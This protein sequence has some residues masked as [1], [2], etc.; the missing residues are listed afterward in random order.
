MQNSSIPFLETA[1][2]LAEA[3]APLLR[4]YFRTPI[5][6][7]EKSDLTPVTLADRA[8]EQ[9]MRHIIRQTHPDHGI[10]GEEMGIQ[11]IE[12]DYLWVLDPIDGTKSFIT[13]KPLFG[14]L[15]ALLYQGQPILGLLEQPILRERWLGG[16]GIFTTLNQQRIQVRSCT[17]LSAAT[18]Y[19]T[20]PHMFNPDE[21]QKFETVRKQI[22]LP[23]YGC[24]CYAYGLLAMG[25]VDLV[26]EAGLAPYDYCA[27]VPIVEQ[28]GGIMT[29]WQGRPLGLHSQGQVIA[30]GDRHLHQQ[31]LELLA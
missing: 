15:I 10:L 27:L 13:G 5:V 21:F 17:H 14:T 20:S 18:L 22:K 6:V 8:V 7:E 29:D 4:H 25:L 19:T 16:V 11:Q 1:Q 2:R 9:A 26:I 30:A 12:A 31:V 23:L 24:D 28:A 3:A